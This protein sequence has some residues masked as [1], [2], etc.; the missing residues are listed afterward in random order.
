MNAPNTK[1]SSQGRRPLKCCCRLRELFPSGV[2]R[3][4]TR[5]ASETREAIS[6]SVVP[7]AR[8]KALASTKR[9]RASPIFKRAWWFCLAAL[10]EP[11]GFEDAAA[12]QETARNRLGLRDA[13]AKRMRRHMRDHQHGHVDDGIAVCSAQ[14]PRP[15]RGRPT[16]V[17]WYS[18]DEVDHSTS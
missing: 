16:G 11:A 3:G 13:A 15:G 17:A 14:L 8:V 4:S 2:E 9:A 1:H 7:T 10:H 12:S 6:I 18:E 5:K